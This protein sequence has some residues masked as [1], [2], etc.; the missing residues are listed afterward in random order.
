MGFLFPKKPEPEA[1]KAMP[2]PDDASSRA[3]DARQKQ[4]IASR[5]GRA[6]TVLSRPT[7][8]GEAGTSSYG[9][10]LLGSAG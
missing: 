5:T 8:G 6:S 9:N 7:G 2:V 10:S 4:L 1:A 3:A